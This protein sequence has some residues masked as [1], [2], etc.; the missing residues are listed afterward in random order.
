MAT[1][2]RT[3]LLTK[4]EYMAKANLSYAPVIL[5]LS[6]KVKH[7][8]SLDMVKFKSLDVE[9]DSIVAL[10]LTKEATEK[11]HIKAGE[12]TKE[13]KIYVKGAKYIQSLRSGVSAIPTMHNRVL[14]EYAKT[15]DKDGMSGD[16]HN[17][18][19]ITSN[20]ENYTSNAQHTIPATG[21]SVT[22]FDRVKDLLALIAT[23]QAQVDGSHMSQQLIMFYYGDELVKFLGSI[24]QDNETPVIE[25]C[26]K[27]W[28]GVRWI[29]IPSAV[30]PDGSGNGLLVVA[31]DLV[32]LHYCQVPEIE[33]DGTNEE[34]NYY[35]ANYIT[36]SLM[37][38]VTEK[39]G[40][41]KQPVAFAA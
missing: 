26:K 32:T 11:A 31:D 19:L 16:K 28:E 38:D 36:G 12:K 13:Y 20:D 27:A 29:K 33:N 21:A 22:D 4:E 25:L 3:G 18:G 9:K 24:T 1:D 37:V 39:D 34:D 35:F 30:L 14:M 8:V 7:E 15:F 6:N 10:P 2:L 17:N 41:I 40:I 23:L 5:S